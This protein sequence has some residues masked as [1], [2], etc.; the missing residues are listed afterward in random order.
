MN[1]GSKGFIDCDEPLHPLFFS[2][3]NKVKIAATAVGSI[4]AVLRELAANPA[5]AYL[6]AFIKYRNG[7]TSIGV[8]RWINAASAYVQNKYTHIV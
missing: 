3:A 4:N 5:A 6:I 2:A 1:L 8:S 7:S